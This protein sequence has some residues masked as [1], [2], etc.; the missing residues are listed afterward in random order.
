MDKKLRFGIVGAAGM[1]GEAN[2]EAAHKCPYGQ[3]VGVTDLNQEKCKVVAEKF[4]A[5]VF[6]SFEELIQSDLIDT[7][8]IATPHPLHH[9][10][11]IAAMKAGKHVITEKPIAVTVREADE[12][13]A[14]AEET[15]RRLGVVF[16]QRFRTISLKAKE[17]ISSG[18]IGPIYRTNLVFSAYKAEV[19]YRQAAWRG[20]WKGE[21]GGVMYN[22]APHPMD[23]FVWLGGMPG[24][25]VAY[26]R[27]LTH[28]IDV[29]DIASALLEYPSG[30]QGMLQCNVVQAPQQNLMEFFGEKGRLTIEGDTLTLDAL[31]MPL[32]KFQAA[33]HKS[34]CAAPR[35]E[36][37]TWTFLPND[38]THNTVYAAFAEK[39]LGGQEPPVNGRE[40]TRSLE[41]AN[42]ITLS[43]FRRKEV[44]LPLDR[45]EYDA[46]LAELK[47][48]P[49]RKR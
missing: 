19:Y 33:E 48:L 23:L 24:K 15:G 9:K 34:I 7:V 46:A 44:S 26:A 36:R 45:A 39:V 49:S 42:A 18:V 1:V 5:R 21:G 4:G 43:S 35:S 3:L 25:V 41:L 16:Q 8:G 6:G 29:E 32:Q 14:V 17:M 20:T 13:A 28:A 31:E 27:T 30:A 10:M 11:A 47:K 22:Q 2:V 40:A 38:A 37:Q 12:M